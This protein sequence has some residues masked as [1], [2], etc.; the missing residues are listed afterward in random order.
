MECISDAWI[1]YF[2][3][4]GL[5]VSL[6]IMM[7]YAIYRCVRWLAPRLDTWVNNYLEIQEKK[8]NIF[9]ENSDKCITTQNRT[10]EAIEK[11]T[12]LI[13]GG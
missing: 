6:L 13:K 11:L 12:N 10:L 1:S 7:F 3:Q 2:N 5:P 4:I 8:S 9:Q